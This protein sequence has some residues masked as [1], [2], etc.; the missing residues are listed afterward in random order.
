M[1]DEA[2]RN[3]PIASQGWGLSGSQIPGARAASSRSNSRANVRAF[4]AALAG[5]ARDLPAAVV[6]IQHPPKP[7]RAGDATGWPQPWTRPWGRWTGRYGRAPS[8]ARWPC[9][10]GWAI[11]AR[12]PTV[13]GILVRLAANGADISQRGNRAAPTAPSTV[14]RRSAVSHTSVVSTARRSQSAG[15]WCGCAEHAR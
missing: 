14:A 13:G 1:E 3:R 9:G 15:C 7:M 2:P 8:R 6:L 5:L 4:L 10:G 11:V 12:G